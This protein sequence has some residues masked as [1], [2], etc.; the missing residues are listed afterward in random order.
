MSATSITVIVVIAVLWLLFVTGWIWHLTG[1]PHP[2]KRLR[3]INV[4][5][6]NRVLAYA[7]FVLQGLAGAA[8]VQLI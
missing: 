8:I 3:F 6:G 1:W 4:L 5:R 7:F 2:P